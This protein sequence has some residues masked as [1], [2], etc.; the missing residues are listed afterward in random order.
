MNI[1]SV[2]LTAY[3][4][5]SI[6]LGFYGCGGTDDFYGQKGD[7]YGEEVEPDCSRLI[8]HSCDVRK[9]SCQRDLFEVAICSRGDEVGVLP[10]VMT[11]DQE[12]LKT[13]L[14]EPDDLEE[15]VSTA[16]KTWTKAFQILGLLPEE[17]SIGN[18]ISDDL[19]EEIVGFYSS[20]TKSLVLVDYGVPNDSDETN[21][22]LIHEFVHALQDQTI[23][24]ENFGEE[25]Q[26]TTDG[27][28]ARKA[29]IEGEA[30]H[31]MVV[32]FSKM[33][34]REPETIKWYEYY[35]DVSDPMLEDIE[36]SEVPFATAI[37]SLPYLVGGSYITD[38]YLIRG[39]VQIPTLWDDP[40]T[41]TVEWMLGYGDSTFEKASL[42]CALPRAP[43]D[44]EQLDRDRLGVA[45]VLAL[46]VEN[47]MSI[48][49]AWELSKKWR[50]GEIATYG[51]EKATDSSIFVAWRTV[52]ESADDASEFAAAL[53]EAGFVTSKRSIERDEQEVLIVAGE[54]SAEL[55]GWTERTE[56]IAPDNAV[57][58]ERPNG[59]VRKIS[60]IYPIWFP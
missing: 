31:F 22:T 43:E 6:S 38:A 1:N 58:D 40:I 41:T 13:L 24:L 51:F 21:I 17:V 53:N 18:A 39:D 9:K 27:A 47:G 28:I 5:L 60:P 29:L 20:E 59:M 54:H 36:N 30:V 26:K 34:R 2:A 57:D 33:A 14:S 15:E 16:Q 12:E 37:S 55:E 25:L 50:W 7:F 45:G 3:V 32:G 56:C 44:A 8:R 11:I 19:A 46:L 35:G 23:G 49:D 10:E 42:S 52:W 4:V 48:G